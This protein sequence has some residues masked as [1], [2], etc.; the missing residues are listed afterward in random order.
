MAALWPTC[1]DKKPP[2]RELSLGSVI[3]LCYWSLLNLELHLVLFG[4]CLRMT[5]VPDERTLTDVVE[6]HHDFENENVY[7]AY[8]AKNDED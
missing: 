2:N 5:Q 7:Y 4:P 8:T 6:V 1:L 3:L